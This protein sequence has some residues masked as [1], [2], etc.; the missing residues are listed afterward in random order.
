MSKPW[1]DY[2]Q[3][4]YSPSQWKRACLIDTTEGEPEDKN[5]YRLPVREPGGTI[6]HAGV[7][8]AAARLEQVTGIS[9]EKKAN[10]A[11][12]LVA[13]YRN[14]LKQDPPEGLLAMADR[15]QRGNE[16]EA[17]ER[18]FTPSLVELRID[19]NNGASRQVGGYAALFMRRSENLGAYVERIHPSFFNKSRA[20]GFPG[21]ICR[22]NHDDN[23][24]LGSTDSGTLRCSLDDTGLLYA[25]DLPQSRQDVYELIQRKDVRKSSFAFMAYDEEW[26][27]TDQGYPQRTLISGKLIDVA[28]VNTPA[29]RD[30]TVG[31]RRLAEYMNLPVQ[32]VE[33]L[34]AEQELRKLFVKT[35]KDNGLV[36]PKKTMSGRA[37]LAQIMSKRPDDPIGNI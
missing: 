13:H 11:R 21:V 8:A 35:D 3:A 32:D 6:N 4:D 34:A 1:S 22:Y 24:M 25:V 37:A 29:Y 33:D 18:I 14:D 10:A 15:S 12:Q 16:F 28:P 9:A 20:D 5:R 31:L 7:R 17:K 30:T 36:R 2:T 26:G 19:P 23:M 27:V